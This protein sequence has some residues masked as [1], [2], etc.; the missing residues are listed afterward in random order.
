LDTGSDIGGS[1]KTAK[2]GFAQK[3]LLAAD[4]TIQHE[5][6]AECIALFDPENAAQVAVALEL[7]RVKR[8]RVMSPE[9][10]TACVE[11]LAAVR[12]KAA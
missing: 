3:K 1:G 11:R 12:M 5:G 4:F 6:D 2:L 8:Q 10:R 7:A 9:Q